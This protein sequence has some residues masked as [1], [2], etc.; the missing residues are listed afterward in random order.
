MIYY[1]NTTRDGW[2]EEHLEDTEF[3]GQAGDE[4]F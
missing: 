4:T 1:R 3:W 2:A